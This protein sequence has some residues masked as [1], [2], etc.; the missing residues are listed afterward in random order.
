MLQR[1]NFKESDQGI[2]QQK[3]CIYK[4]KLKKR[5]NLTR[6]DCDQKEKPFAK[7]SWLGIRIKWWNFI[8]QNKDQE[9]QETWIPKCD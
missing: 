9:K 7:I 4:Y 6:C 1:C 8:I 5:V 2:K 3:S